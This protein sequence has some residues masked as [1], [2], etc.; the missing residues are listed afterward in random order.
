VASEGVAILALSELLTPNAHSNV[1][2]FRRR[3]KRCLFRIQTSTLAQVLRPIAF[4]KA[5][6]RL[7][8]M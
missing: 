8:I 5:F 6:R 2:R 1:I 3:V 7:G 4:A